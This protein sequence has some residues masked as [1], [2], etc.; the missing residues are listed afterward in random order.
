MN[1]IS[2]TVLI[3]FAIA[4]VYFFR[5]K[6]RNLLAPQTVINISR[7]ADTSTC[8]CPQTQPTPPA[9]QPA[10]QDSEPE[11]N[12]EDLVEVMTPTNGNYSTGSFAYTLN[13]NTIF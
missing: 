5:D 1:K 3:L 2:T 12:D 13:A 8:N 6:L 7:G 4:L 11:Y 9:T 10:A